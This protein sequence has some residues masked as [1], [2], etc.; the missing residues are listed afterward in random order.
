MCYEETGQLTLT[1][2]TDQTGTMAAWT[3][4]TG[5]MAAWTGQTGTMATWTDQTG[6]MAAWT[7]QTGT[8]QTLREPCQI[9]RTCHTTVRGDCYG[10][11][12]RTQLTNQVKSKWTPGLHQH[13]TEKAVR[14]I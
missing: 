9:C 13:S 4:Q 10:P 1:V 2:W 6:T 3:D 11:T 14:D 12:Y 5:T 7:D 8:M